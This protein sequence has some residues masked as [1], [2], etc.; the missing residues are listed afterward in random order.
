MFDLTFHRLDRTALAPA[1][2]RGA[3]D[4]PPRIAAFFVPRDASSEQNGT[5]VSQH[6]K[7]DDAGGDRR[8]GRR[9]GAR[10]LTRCV[11]RRIPARRRGT[12]VRERRRAP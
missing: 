12:A 6:R 8:H 11:L 3:A 5:R 10:F 7:H 4:V 9:C 1:S 2:A